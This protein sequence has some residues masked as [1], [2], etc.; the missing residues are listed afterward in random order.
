[1]DAKGLFSSVNGSISV[2]SVGITENSAVPTQYPI[3]TELVEA[4]ILRRAQDRA[5][6]EDE[7]DNHIFLSKLSTNSDQSTQ[8]I[9]HLVDEHF[10]YVVGGR[11]AKQ[12]EN[13]R[14]HLHQFFLNLGRSMLC[15]SWL[16]T[17][18]DNRAYT[19]G[20]GYMSPHGMSHSLVKDILQHLT[21]S[22]LVKYKQGKV[23]ETGGM[24][25]RIFPTGELQAEIA[26][27]AL[28]TTQEF[29]GHYLQFTDPS[30]PYQDVLRQLPADHSDISAMN[31]INEFLAGQTWALKGP[32]LLKYSKNPFTGGRLYTPY[33]NLPSRNYDIRKRTLLNG[34]AISEPDYSANHLRLN[35]ALNASQDAGDTPYED[36]MAI[37][38][39]DLDRALVKAFV[40]RAMGAGKRNR[41]RNS[42]RSAGCKDW[43]F[44][45]MEEATLKRYPKLVL[46]KSFGS[47][48]QSL[49]GAILKDVMLEGIKLGIPALPVHDA[50][51]VNTVH[52]EWAKECMIE[53]WK[54]HI[55][56]TSSAPRVN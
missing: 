50:L 31:L 18:E 12:A 41:A 1:M 7:Y 43:Q 37:A 2:T 29:H 53:K 47:H 42:M 25:S 4:E 48:A 35:L 38:G 33:Q 40:T 55:G 8:I 21:A 16:A 34:E 3:H 32:V 39:H 11:R 56:C 46:Y 49:E 26:L 17:P 20:R 6:P 45:L 28:H 51:A 19:K 24:V 9:E 23:Y 13:M 15:N 52:T 10:P 22:G 27:L 30:S 5:E 36:I 54:A 14:W 44:N